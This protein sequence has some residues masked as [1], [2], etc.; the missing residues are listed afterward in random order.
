MCLMIRYIKAWDK[1]SKW[2]LNIE[3][4]FLTPKSWIPGGE[5]LIFTDV[6]HYWRLPLRQFVH[7][8]TIDEYD[9]TMLVPCVHM[10]SQIN[11]GDVTMWSQKRPSLATMAKMSDWWLFLAEMC[12]QHMQEIT[13]CPAMSPHKI[14]WLFPDISLTILWF[15]LTIRH[16]IGISLL[17]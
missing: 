13:G 5:K 2:Y 9:I 11:F 15:S 10:T 7:G 17:P 8:R 6:I 1:G 16:I 14:P 3:T 12:V 4:W